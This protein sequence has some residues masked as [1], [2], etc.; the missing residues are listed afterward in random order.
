MDVVIRQ[1]FGDGYIFRDDFITI[2]P[3]VKKE[4]I[5]YVNK[6]RR[7]NKNEKNV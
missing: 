2:Y 5:D 3:Q 1:E 4:F 7:V 6:V